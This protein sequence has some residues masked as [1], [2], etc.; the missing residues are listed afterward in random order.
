MKESVPATEQ[1]E[2]NQGAADRDHKRV[3]LD[4]RP[5][6][7]GTPNHQIGCHQDAM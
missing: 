5:I 4:P 3:R 2:L 6:E 7:R 1:V